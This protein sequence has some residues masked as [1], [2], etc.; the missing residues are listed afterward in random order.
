MLGSILRSNVI[1][2]GVYRALAFVYE[3]DMDMGVSVCRL[4]SPWLVE[5]KG[6]VFIAFMY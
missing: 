2:S 4:L 3:R 6:F 5:T 1:V